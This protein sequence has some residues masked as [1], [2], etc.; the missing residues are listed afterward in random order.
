MSNND[1]GNDE[2]EQ[3]NV[4]GEEEDIKTD[5]EET[6]DKAPK[7]DEDGDDDEGDD[8]DSDADEDKG[9]NKDKKPKDWKAEAL[10]L[11]AIL[12]RKAKKSGKKSE[13]SK[14]PEAEE[15]E[16]GTLSSRDVLTLSN[17]GIKEEEDIDEVINFAG[18]RKISISEALKDKTLKTILAERKEERVTAEATNAGGGRRGSRRPSSESILSDADQGK[19]PENPEDLAEARAIARKK[20]VKK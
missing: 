17:A 1:T 11:Q 14:K 5:E 8:D 15:S 6:D 9:G 19:Y 18:Y 4:E 16:E 7:G 3:E 12:D 13:T 10:K 20:K 2:S